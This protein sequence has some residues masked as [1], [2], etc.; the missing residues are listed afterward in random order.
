MIKRECENI[1]QSYSLEEILE[2]NDLT[3]DEV[4]YFLV[5]QEFIKLPN[6][7]PVDL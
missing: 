7:L 3:E 5:E 2:L 1:L 4:L 6:P